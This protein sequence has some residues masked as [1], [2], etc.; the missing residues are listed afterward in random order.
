MIL[1]FIF[2]TW[3]GGVVLGAWIAGFILASERYTIFTAKG[4]YPDKVIGDW[5]AAIFW[6]LPTLWRWAEAGIRW[7]K[8]RKK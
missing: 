8:S 2:H 4:K 7:F 1:K 5:L 6:P 3:T